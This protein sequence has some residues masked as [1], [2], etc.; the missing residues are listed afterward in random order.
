MVSQLKDLVV[1][2]GRHDG[3]TSMA[4]FTSS[5]LHPTNSISFSY[6]TSTSQL[7]V[8]FSHKKS[9]PA[10]STGQPNTVK[11]V[12]TYSLSIGPYPGVRII[13]WHLE[14]AYI[15]VE[16]RAVETEHGSERGKWRNLSVLVAFDHVRYPSP[17]G[18]QRLR[19]R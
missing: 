5:S 17:T 14:P 7:A 11:I 4:L 18:Q 3:S 16:S 9:A 12:V 10:T 1:R 8:F 2:G 15:V 19:H 13:G 6:K